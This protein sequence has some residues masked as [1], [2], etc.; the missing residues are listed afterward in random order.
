MFI[1]CSKPLNQLVTHTDKTSQ[2]DWLPIVQDLK[3]HVTGGHRET[4]I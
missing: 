4:E 2:L 1:I 3:A